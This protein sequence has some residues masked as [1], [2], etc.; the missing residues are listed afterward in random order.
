MLPSDFN[1]LSCF[2]LRRNRHTIYSAK[3]TI[4]KRQI[5]KFGTKWTETVCSCSCPMVCHALTHHALAQAIFARGT[6]AI[7][8]ASQK[9]HD[10]LE[11]DI[12]S[13]SRQRNRVFPHP[14][15]NARHASPTDVCSWR[16]GVSRHAAAPLPK[17][18]PPGGE[19]STVQDQKGAVTPCPVSW[20]FFQQ[21]T[22]AS[23][24][25][26]TLYC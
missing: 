9:P 6:L 11:D 5:C 4:K 24:P 15:Q 3:Q 14:R 13:I 19:V 17:L 25:S 2:H 7:S 8:P 10:R 12:C 23:T 1:V 18:H 26:A 22:H 21:P 16:V 20:S